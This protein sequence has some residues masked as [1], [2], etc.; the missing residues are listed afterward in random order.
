M[1]IQVAMRDCAEENIL[2]LSDIFVGDEQKMF[3]N[4]GTFL[5]QRV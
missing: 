5:K 1:C 3:C 2:G 4:K